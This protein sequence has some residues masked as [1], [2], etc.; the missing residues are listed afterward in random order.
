LIGSIS[1]PESPYWAR[2]AV[3]L[4]DQG[5]ELGGDAN[6][7]GQVDGQP[8]VRA[9]Q[10]QRGGLVVVAVLEHGQHVALEEVAG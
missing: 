10:G 1:P 4:V 8:K 5:A 2:A 3:N 6:L 9:G 7:A